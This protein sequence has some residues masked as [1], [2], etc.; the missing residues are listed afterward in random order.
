MKRAE[1]IEKLVEDAMKVCCF[2]WNHEDESIPEVR[3]T[4]EQL[5]KEF[6]KTIGLFQSN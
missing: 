2:D 4:K 5:R 3:Y 6:S 1:L